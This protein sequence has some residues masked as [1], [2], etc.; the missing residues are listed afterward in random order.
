MK[1][2]FD[3]LLI[4]LVA[5]GLMLGMVATGYILRFPLPPGSNKSSTLWNLTRH[6]WGDVHFWISLALLG[7]VLLH[8]CLHWQWIVISVKRRFFLGKAS[9]GS[10][11]VAGLMTILALAGA[12]GLFGWAAQHNVEQITEPR[13]GVCPLPTFDVGDNAVNGGPTI[14]KT[15]APD[16]HPKVAFWKDVYPILERA[17]LSCHGPKQQ[18]ADFRVDRK[19]D[20]FGKDGNPPL[21][22]PGKSAESALIAIVS[23]KRKD[24]PRPDRHRLPDEQVALLRAWIDAGASWPERTNH[25]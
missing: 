15:P 19:E 11:V 10:S 2:F 13:D 20:F 14:A 18:R 16:G 17:C 25:E 3:N 8:I 6:Q 12:L 22:V 1:R 4:D 7:V 9:P 24:I 21:I 23:G 5:A